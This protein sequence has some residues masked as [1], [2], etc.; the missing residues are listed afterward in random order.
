MIIQSDSISMNSRRNYHSSEAGYSNVTRWDQSGATTFAL[1]SGYYRNEEIREEY[2]SGTNN[3]QDEINAKNNEQGSSKESLK[4]LMSRLQSTNSVQ[5]ASLQDSANALHKIRAQAI[6]YLL[7]ILFG[8]KYSDYDT[9]FSQDNS[10]FSDALS[11]ATATDSTVSSQYGEG[12]QDYTFF[13]QSEQ[14]TTCFDTK[15]TVRTADGREIS[16]NMNIEMSRSFTQVAEN[17]VDFGKPRLC[18]PLVINL[19]S[20]I[21]GLSDQKFFFD[22][23]ADGNEESI[24]MLDSQSGYLALDKNGDGI[25]NDG[26]EL[27]GATSGNGFSE[28]AQYD[29]DQNGWIDEADEIFSKLKIWVKDADGNDKLMSLSEAGVGAIY[30]GSTDTNFSLNSL[31]DNHTNGVIRKTSMF[32]YENGYSGTV[33]QLDLA[34]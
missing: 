25:I 11:A 30:L 9:A 15:G 1:Q 16:F 5:R 6:D 18:D 12:G 21:A 20:N 26:S 17:Y 34:T 23:D 10:G 7:Y 4:D 32:L 2:S 33:Q 3:A 29:Q 24:S 28:L 31:T 27:F 13:Y 19:G 14:E 8:R 22:L